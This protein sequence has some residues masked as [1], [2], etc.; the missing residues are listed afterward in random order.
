MAGWMRDLLSSVSFAGF[1]TAGAAV[2]PARTFDC[3]AAPPPVSSQRSGPFS[4]GGRPVMG[5]FSMGLPGL[6]NAGG[7]PALACSLL[8]RL[9]TPAVYACPLRA[10]KRIGSPFAFGSTLGRTPHKGRTEQAERA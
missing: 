4:A 10:V 9:P 3:S 5:G 1:G 8:G 7:A 2:A 6:E